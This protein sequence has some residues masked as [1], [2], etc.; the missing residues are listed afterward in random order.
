MP[1][2]VSTSWLAYD[3]AGLQQVTTNAQGFCGIE[4]MPR[5]NA[6]SIKVLKKTA[7]TEEGR[8]NAISLGF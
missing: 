5:A 1:A 2:G 7:S 6:L 4:V 8:R 3:S